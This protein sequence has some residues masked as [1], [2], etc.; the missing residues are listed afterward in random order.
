[1]TV[2]LSKGKKFE[3]FKLKGK[4]FDLSNFLSLQI[5]FGGHFCF[6]LGRGEICEITV[7]PCRPDGSQTADLPV[8]LFIHGWCCNAHK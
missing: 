3:S 1:M 6:S 5:K 8:M 7:L 2:I 4:K